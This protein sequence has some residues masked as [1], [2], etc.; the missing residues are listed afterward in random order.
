MTIKLGKVLQAC[1]KEA[2]LSQQEVADLICCSRG[3]YSCWE[4]DEG[5]IPLTKLLSLLQHYGLPLITFVKLVQ[6]QN[7]GTVQL[8]SPPDL[9][10]NDISVIKAEFALL[11]KQIVV[12]N[13]LI[14][15]K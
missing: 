6:D 10:F 12:L 1:R 5:E 3:T 4:H 7:S 11:S 2:N 14:N 9:E 13:Q 15:P 8:L